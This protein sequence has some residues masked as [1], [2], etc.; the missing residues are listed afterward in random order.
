MK[1][2]EDVGTGIFG[3]RR[4]VVFGTRFEWKGVAIRD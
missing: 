4:G 3:D 2:G 1:S